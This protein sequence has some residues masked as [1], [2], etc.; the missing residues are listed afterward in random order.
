M[1]PLKVGDFL[2]YSGI[3]VNNEIICYSIVAN[4]GIFTAPATAPGFI[5]VEDALIGIIDNNPDTEFARARV[6]LDR[7][8]RT[9]VHS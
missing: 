1:A 2:E 3:K 4:I 6:S 7:L 9:V 8:N 5:R